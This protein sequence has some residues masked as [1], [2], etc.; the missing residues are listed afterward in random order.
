[1]VDSLRPVLFLTLCVSLFISISAQTCRTH[2]FP[3]ENGV[4]TDF[5][6]CNDLPVLNS[7]I[8]WKYDPATGTVN[9]AYRHTNIDSNGWIAWAINPNARGMQGSQALVAILKDGQVTAYTSP[10]PATSYSTS[11][12]RGNLSFEVPALAARFRDRKSQFCNYTIAR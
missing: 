2:V 12:A 5:S 10:L 8:H 6:A 1:M 4:S 11:L 7:F 9:I 3:S